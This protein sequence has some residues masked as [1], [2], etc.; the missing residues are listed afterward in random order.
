MVDVAAY[1]PIISTLL[2]VVSE[3]LFE[4]ENKIHCFFH[5]VFE[6]LAEAPIAKSQL[7]PQPVESGVP[8]QDK[9]VGC[10]AK[11]TQPRCQSCDTIKHIAMNHEIMSTICTYVFG[12][13]AYLY[14][15]KTESIWNHWS[16][17]LVVIAGYVDHSCA[18]FGMTQHT[19]NHSGVTLFPTPFVL[20]DTPS[21]NDISH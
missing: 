12:L 21:V 13:I 6:I 14:Q 8:Y 3:V 19:P 1:D 2:A 5:S 7:V 16:Q 17:E 20:L 11:E 4:L 18:A 10:V 15:A 9:V